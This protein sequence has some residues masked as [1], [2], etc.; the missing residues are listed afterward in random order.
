MSRGSLYASW[1]ILL[2]PGD[3]GHRDLSQNF[4]LV[5]FWQEQKYLS[6]GQSVWWEART[7]ALAGLRCFMKNS[8]AVCA[9]TTGI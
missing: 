8:G 5:C 2:S 9:M 1:D 7:D 6:Q 3:Q 4:S